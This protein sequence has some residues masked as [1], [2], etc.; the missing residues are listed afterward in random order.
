MH[1]TTLESI[2]PPGAHQKLV[3]F[4]PDIVEV[5]Q[6]GQ[7][8]VVDRGD[9]VLRR[10]GRVSALAQ[11]HLLPPRLR[12]AQNLPRRGIHR[13]IAVENDDILTVVLRPDL[14]DVKNRNGRTAQNLP[15]NPVALQILLPRPGRRRQIEERL[16]PTVVEHAQRIQSIFSVAVVLAPYIFTELHAERKRPAVPQA[17]L[18]GPDPVVN[19]SPAS[20]GEFPERVEVAVVVEEPVVRMQRL[21][22]HP[23][24]QPGRDLVARHIAAVGADVDGIVLSYPAVLPDVRPIHRYVPEEYGNVL[25]GFPDR[26]AVCREILN[27]R[28][29][30]PQV[31]QDIAGNAEFRKNDQFRALCPPFVDVMQHP[32]HVQIRACRLHIHLDQSDFG[33]RVNASH[34]CRAKDEGLV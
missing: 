5:P 12:S 26:F 28:I 19:R 10:S 34:I 6:S 4:L 27:E 3:L 9:L 17:D 1:V 23:G 29:H 2:P 18:K 11:Y 25:T 33:Q 16:R 32:I 13:R 14:I 8:G 7:Y 21:G 31:A 22:M 30:L 20:I 24:G 15:D